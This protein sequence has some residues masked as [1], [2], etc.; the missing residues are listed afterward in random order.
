MSLNSKALGLSF[1][2]LSA[3]W[4]F[5]VGVIA[6]TTGWGAPVVAIVG[7]WYPGYDATFVGALIGAV[8]GFIEGFLF[9]FLAAWLY[10][11]LS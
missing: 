6:S 8:L 2:I 4:V 10:N 11:K 9:G 5:A 7:G 1:G 3:V